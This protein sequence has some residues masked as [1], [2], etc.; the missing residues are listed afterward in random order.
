MTMTLMSI[1]VPMM[2]ARKPPIVLAMSRFRM[3][4]YDLATEGC[5]EG[6][7]EIPAMTPASTEINWAS[8]IDKVTAS[9]VLNA[10]APNFIF[11]QLRKNIFIESLY[12]IFTLIVNH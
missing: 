9:P 10:R 11:I 12:P 7:A 2:A 5:V 3:V 6:T 1:L 4:E 8:I